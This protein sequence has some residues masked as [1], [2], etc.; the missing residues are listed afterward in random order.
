MQLE[1]LAQA[2]ALLAHFSIKD[3]I[4]GKTLMICAANDVKWKRQVVPG[5]TLQVEV[6]FIKRRKPFFMMEG[7]LTCEGQICCSAAITAAE[8]G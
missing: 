2:C 6:R 1:A 4:E 5:D 3:E 8:V 7:S